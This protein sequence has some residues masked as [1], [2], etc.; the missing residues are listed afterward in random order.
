MLKGRGRWK[1]N[2]EGRAN[3]GSVGAGVLEGGVGGV[4]SWANAL[5]YLRSLT[6]ANN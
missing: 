4:G 5:K 3:L 1:R 2:E 6:Q